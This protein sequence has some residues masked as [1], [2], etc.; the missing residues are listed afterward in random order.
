LQEYSNGDSDAEDL[1]K[2]VPVSG[3]INFV[4]GWVVAGIYEKIVSIV[5]IVCVS[6]IEIF[7]ILS[8]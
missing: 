6:Y 7:Y 4:I 1:K 5:Q 8:C 2:G 3:T